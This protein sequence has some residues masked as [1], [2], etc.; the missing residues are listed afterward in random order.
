MTR[1]GSFSTI[2]VKMHDLASLRRPR[3]LVGGVAIVASIFLALAIN[4]WRQDRQVR[5]EEQQFLQDLR[6]E[7]TSLN[8]ILARHLTYH[9]RTLESLEMLLLAIEN[10]SSKDAGPIIDSPLL[11]MI[12]PVTWD[13]GDGA[14]DELLGSG[15]T[16]ILTNSMLRA[17]LSAWE[18]VFGEYL[19]DQEIANKRIDETH[20]PY[21][22]SKNVAVGAVMTE[23][24]DD[25]STPERSISA[26]PDVIR[27]LLEDP[28]FHLLVEVRYRFKEHL[29]VEIEIAIT[30]AE[31]IL[32][33]IEKSVN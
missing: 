18:R 23:W 1:S 9:L 5:F 14:L 20:I 30:A 26:D 24:N 27:M 10:G 15:R 19:G 31:A 22:A 7:F 11:E 13:H 16:K 25:W 4:A 21:F 2:M 6:E 12:V 28:K 8:N 29:I 3:V 33:E 32:A 17:K